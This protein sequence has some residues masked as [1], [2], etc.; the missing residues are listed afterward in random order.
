MYEDH[1]IIRKIMNHFQSSNPFYYG[2]EKVNTTK[3]TLL[4]PYLL[5][6][7]KIRYVGITTKEEIISV[8]LNLINGKIMNNM[9][10][11]LDNI[12]FHPTISPYCYMISPIIYLESG[13]KRIEKFCY[14][15]LEQQTYDWAISANHTMRA[16]MNLVN[17]IIQDKRLRRKQQ[18]NIQA[19][20]QPTIICELINGG[21]LHIRPDM[22]P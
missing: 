2:F 6:N 10:E 1:P 14:H 17:K 20:L 18:E 9:M 11:L 4:H 8:G 7:I 21:M 13:I 12:S 19:R 5:L 22:L 3:R 16:E 15:Y